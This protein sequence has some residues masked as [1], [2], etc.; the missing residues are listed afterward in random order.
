M[1]NRPPGHHR[2]RHPAPKHPHRPHPLHP[3][4]ILLIR[5]HAPTQPRPPPEHN[6]RPLQR[7]FS[8]SH[9]SRPSHR[10]PRTPAGY[11]HVR[12]L[13]TF[14]SFTGSASSNALSNLPP[15]GFTNTSP[16]TSLPLPLPNTARTL[17]SPPRSTST[18]LLLPLK[19]PTNGFPPQTGILPLTRSLTPLP[20]SPPLQMPLQTPHHPLHPRMQRHH[21]EIHMHPHP[22]RREAHP[23]RAPVS[24]DLR[25]RPR[26]VGEEVGLRGEGGHAQGEDLP[27]DV[28]W[29]CRCWRRHVV[30]I[31]CI[32]RKN[33]DKYVP[34]RE[35]MVLD[36][37]FPSLA[38][39]AVAYCVAY[40]N[41]GDHYLITIRNE[42]RSVLGYLISHSTRHDF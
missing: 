20:S 11:P 22:Q 39:R 24:A 14:P 8:N 19:H 2:R 17:S 28:V 5:R 34:G 30:V 1:P 38:L 35:A 37:S 29:E 9:S 27:E 7:P 32:W 25:E 31:R 13:F 12:I 42:L 16:S 26:G 4:Q 40:G 36:V 33:T 15:P 3:L 21:I 18:S 10:T 41:D 23:R 6:T